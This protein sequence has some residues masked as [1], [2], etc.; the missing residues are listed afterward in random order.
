M[1]LEKIRYTESY[2][3]EMFFFKDIDYREIDAFQT[4]DLTLAEGEKANGYTALTTNPKTVNQDYI[5]NEIKVIDTII[6]EEYYNNWSRMVGDIIANYEGL[7]T[8]TS[9]V[10]ETERERK[11]FLIEAVQYMGLDLET[12]QQKREDLISLGDGSPRSLNLN[13]LKMLSSGY[14]YTTIKPVE[15]TVNE[16][17]LPYINLAF[18]ESV[19]KIDQESEVLLKVINNDHVYASFEISKDINIMGEE[20]VLSLK[21]EMV[22]TADGGINST[23]YDFLVKRVD[24]LYYYPEI[25]F[26]YNDKVYTGFFVDIK[27]EGNK[28]IIVLM[29]KDFV[30][31]FSNAVI[32]DVEIYIQDY[33]AFEVPKS[34]IKKEDDALKIDMVTKGYFNESMQVIVQK[35]NR[36]NAI[37]KESDNPELNSGMRIRIH[38]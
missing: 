27:E 11:T 20:N 3:S 24:Q 36:G 2:Q 5:N 22:G 23:Y 30:N 9:Q 1:L 34:A 25:R 29:I 15:K 10:S 14:I 28:K 32:G 38:P 16:N 18:L 7:S 19:S 6:S 31:D 37:L 8:I 17:M 33:D 12:L 13:E 4:T 26:K 35:Y 21:E